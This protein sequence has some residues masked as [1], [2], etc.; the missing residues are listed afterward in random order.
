ME[1]SI[2]GSLR[3]TIPFLSVER[4][5]SLPQ[6]DYPHTKSRNHHLPLFASR[7]VWGFH[8]AVTSVFSRIAS[9]LALGQPSRNLIGTVLAAR[10]AF[11]GGFSLI[12]FRPGA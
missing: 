12:F 11:P 10:K 2:S 7:M 1:V 6:K 9:V 8:F 4:G 3:W 5:G